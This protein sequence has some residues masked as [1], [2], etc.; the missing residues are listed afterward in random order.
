MIVCAF[1]SI[2]GMRFPDRAGERAIDRLGV[3]NACSGLFPEA[4]RRSACS[5]RCS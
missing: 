3:S 4:A 1:G 2:R 5:T